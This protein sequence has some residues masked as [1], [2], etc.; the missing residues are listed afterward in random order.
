MANPIHDLMINP[1]SEVYYD[2]SFRATI[3]TYL[4]Y[5]RER[6]DTRI[7]PVQADDAYRYE[8]DLYGL[9]LTL[10]IL[11]EHLFIVMRV[12]D[13]TSSSDLTTIIDKL[14]VPS[15]DQINAIVRQFT[16]THKIS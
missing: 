5:L 14:I 10:G 6:P 3:E 16:V 1:G 8:G 13:Y 12:N 11:P 7:L 9:M 2:E 15:P 4:P